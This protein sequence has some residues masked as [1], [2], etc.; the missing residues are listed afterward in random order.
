MGANLAADAGVGQHLGTAYRRLRLLVQAVI[1]LEWAGCDLLEPCPC[2][3]V[4]PKALC[5][6]AGRPRCL[7]AANG[8]W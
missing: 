2:P 3:K 8:F 6:L 5:P 1:G 7:D 4:L